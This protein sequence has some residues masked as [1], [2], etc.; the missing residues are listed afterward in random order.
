MNEEN[1]AAF[2]TS[3]KSFLTVYDPCIN[4]FRKLFMH[5]IKGVL[6]EFLG[7]FLRTSMMLNVQKSKEIHFY[8]I[9]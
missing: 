3:Y 2:I 1:V 9:F 6:R 4:L 5:P 7:G 8:F